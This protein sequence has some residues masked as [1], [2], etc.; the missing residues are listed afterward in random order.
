MLCQVLVGERIK[1][2]REKESINS[3]IH[4]QLPSSGTRDAVSVC[5]N[6]GSDDLNLKSASIITIYNP[7]GKSFHSFESHFPQV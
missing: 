5:N 7:L 1:R 3:R 2:T 6:V 4:H